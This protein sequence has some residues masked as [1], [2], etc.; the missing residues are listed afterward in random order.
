MT[1]RNGDFLGELLAAGELTVGQ[2]RVEPGYSLTH[3]DDAGRADLRI[4][5]DPHE[6]IALTRYDD[7]G[8]YRPLKTAPNLRRGWR[9]DLGSVAEVLRT[10]DFIYPAAIGTA[11]AEKAGEV[12]PVALRETLG[13]QTGMYAVA[14]KISDDQAVTLI[15][16]FCH[17]GCLRRILWTISPSVPSPKDPRLSAGLSLWCAEACNLLVAEARAVVKKS[18]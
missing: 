14:K 4:F 12:Q 11:R 7:A 18:G 9:F 8:R 6:A 1:G 3:V 15:Q 16:D 13:R 17:R 2:V 5:T 10:L